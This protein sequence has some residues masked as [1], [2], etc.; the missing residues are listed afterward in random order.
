M[1]S[2]ARAVLFFLA[3]G[4]VALATACDEPASLCDRATAIPT[5]T[6]MSD[7]NTLMGSDF[8]RSLMASENE[9]E[10]IVRYSRK[11]NKDNLPQSVTLVFDTQTLLLK[12]K[13]VDA[14][15]QG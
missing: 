5:Q 4:S 13:D 15:Y 2:R 7:V 14:C 6:E 10:T 12:S 11:D 9:S 8:E 3:I 1:V